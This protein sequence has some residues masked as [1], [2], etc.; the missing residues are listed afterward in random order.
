MRQNQRTEHLVS[1]GGIVYRQN[2]DMVEVVLCGRDSPE[3]WGLPKGTPAP[4][5][6]R[7]Q[8]ALREV[9]EETGLE[10]VIDRY[11]G[12]IQYW[13]SRKAESTRYHKTVHF[14]LMSPDGGDMSRHDHEFDTVRW[15]P[16]AEALETLTYENEVKIVKKGVSLV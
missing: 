15:F 1:A 13:F 12:S 14:Y 5:E 10:V 9:T 6:T 16:V 4:D 7:E 11:V 3:T 2:T 8:T